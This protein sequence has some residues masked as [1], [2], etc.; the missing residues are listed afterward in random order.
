MLSKLESPKELLT[1]IEELSA[2][3][4]KQPTSGAGAK[5]L[6]GFGAKIQEAESLRKIL[7]ELSDIKTMLS[8]SIIAI[9]FMYLVSIGLVMTTSNVVM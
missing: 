9:G 3:L 4:K 5:E 1:K 7:S 2:L 6:L 8:S